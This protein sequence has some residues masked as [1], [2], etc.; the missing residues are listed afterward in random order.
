L[1]YDYRLTSGNM[2]SDG[3]NGYTYDAE[4]HI[5]TAVNPATS[6]TYDG[7]GQRVRKLV[8]G[9]E[10]VRF[11]YGLGGEL[12]AE[13]DG[14]SG[15]LKKEYVYGG[16]TVATIEPT[17]VNSNGTR[18]ATADHLGSPRVVTNSSGGVVS[19]HD[20]KP[21]GEELFAGTGGRTVGMG[22]SVVD[23][24]RKKFTGYERDNETSL[25]FAQMRYYSASQ[26]RFT[27]VDPA[28]ADPFMPQTFNKYQYVQ[29][30]P[31]RYVDR[32]GAY[33]EDV[34]RDLTTMLA[35]AV[36]FT[37][38]ESVKIGQEDQ[39]VD[40]DSRNPVQFDLDGPGYRARRDFHFTT[41]K[42]RN[43]L[44]HDFELRSFGSQPGLGQ[45]QSATR[46][47]A[48]YALGTYLHA[49][50]DSYS[51][52][53]F[54]PRI[55]HMLEGHGPDKTFK[56]ALMANM[57]A[58]ATYEALVKAMKA[59]GFQTINQIEWA[60]I[61]P[62]VYRFNRS[63]SSEEKKQILKE[64]R[65]FIETERLRMSYSGFGCISG[66]KRRWF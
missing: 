58:K 54:G 4:G 22:F 55:G 1:I 12:I 42:R 25:D 47:Q 5:K 14:A 17:A 24:N 2:T 11:V 51:H 16:G 29:N 7:G 56:D 66:S 21:F 8:G 37:W 59:F 35:Y 61:K 44:W 30:N 40:E 65:E 48:F 39:R 46:D 52:A 32:T 57:M 3:I 23:G 38:H 63:K 60:Q 34:H 62:F 10:N 31:L 53:K 28:G 36:G 13:F 26:G 41:E 43:E 9:G 27:G 45:F 64:M 20:Y 15:S 18:Y 33:E 49:F 19:R 6:Y 50:Q